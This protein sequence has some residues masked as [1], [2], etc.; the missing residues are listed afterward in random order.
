VLSKMSQAPR[1]KLKIAMVEV[2][3]LD[4]CIHRF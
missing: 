1:M 2:V 3:K 4:L